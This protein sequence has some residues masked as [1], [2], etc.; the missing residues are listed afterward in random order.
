MIINP[1]QSMYKVF[2]DSA[3][4]SPN[5]PCFIFQ[6]KTFKYKDVLKNVNKFA[7]KL[8]ELG[9]KKDDVVSVCLPNIP[10]VIYLLYSL[11]QIGAICN[12]LHPLLN[13]EQ[14]REN[15]KKTGSKILFFLDQN[16][17]EI[18]PLIEE[19]IQLISCCPVEQ[20]N[21]VV[22]LVYRK[23][24]KEK[25]YFNF[26]KR[27]LTTRDFLKNKNSLEDFDED[28]KK[29]SIYLHSGGT[30]GESKTIALSNYAIN[31]LTQH[32]TLIMNIP[33]A[34]GTYMLSVLP[35]FHGFGLAMGVHAEIT[36][37]GC[38]VLMP[39][40]STKETIKYLKKGVITFIIGVPTLYEALLNNKNFNGKILKNIREC[41]VG[42][43]TV[44]DSLRNR[45]NN[46]LKQNGSKGR[47]FEGYG[48]T[49]TVTVLC[50]NIFKS[51]KD[52]SVGKPLPGIECKVID[53]ETLKEVPPNKEGELVVR[54]TTLMNGYRFEK[55]PIPHKELFVKIGSG[56]EWLR[57]GDYCKID[58]DGFIYFITRLK[59]IYK[60]KGINVFPVE[61]E[62]LVKGLD[63]V[64]SCA[65]IGVPDPKFGSITKLFVIL[66]K[67]YRGQK[68]T[69]QISNLIVEKLGIYSKPREIVYVDKLPQTMVGKIDVKKLH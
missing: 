64:F 3:L 15:L 39:K 22:K 62:N 63:Y 43:D 38:N 34:R 25:F 44:S 35:T 51:F 9:I 67:T 42:G 29:D 10:D 57:T 53:T 26:D 65:A 58:E 14:L 47:L 56:E 30:T 20:F 49:E 52:G 36:Y 5:Y 66:N 41:F 16:Y 69:E 18:S 50:V 4:R 48:L 40:F 54:G 1:N 31:S 37:S 68:P 60:V 6:H 19:G 11:N 61:I 13:R 2:K 8:K 33:D 59:R 21:C 28:Y 24:N 12:M 23:Q 32:G 7:S 46:L 17:N 55:H 45:Y 27:I